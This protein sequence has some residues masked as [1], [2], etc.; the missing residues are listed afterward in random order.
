MVKLMKNFRPTTTMT[1]KSP[2]N[3][4]NLLV[5]NTFQQFTR[6]C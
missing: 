3:T 5:M 4:A 6:K 2:E 1:A